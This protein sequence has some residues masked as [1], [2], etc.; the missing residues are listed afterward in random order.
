MSVQ[1]N[2]RIIEK[3]FAAVNTRDVN[4]YSDL[5]ADNI[6]VRST[7]LPEP[8]WGREAA[9]RQME[10]TLAPFRNYRIELRNMVVSDEQFVCE[11]EFTGNHNGAFNLEPD[12]LTAP[13]NG[14]RVP[15]QAIIFVAIIREGKVVELY[16][17]PDRL[18]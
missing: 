3:W 5:L 6:V 18:S 12:T 17:Y 15:A 14:N 7:V 1:E 4:R 16:Q 10:A 8:V 9:H 2:T 11:L 13:L